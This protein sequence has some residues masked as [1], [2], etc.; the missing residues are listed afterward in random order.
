MASIVILTSDRS[1]AAALHA[2]LVSAGHA[3]LIAT[4]AGALEVAL[5]RRPDLGVVDGGSFTTESDIWHWLFPAVGDRPLA[6][7][8]LVTEAAVSQW[9]THPGIDDM[10][11]EPWRKPELLGRVRRL[12]WKANKLAPEERIVRQD[13]TIDD[14][15][16]EVKVGARKVDLTYREYQL[17]KYLAINPGRVVR[18]ETLLD[19]VWGMDY[20]GGDRT[21]D[22]HVRRL[23]SKLEDA[24]HVFI[25]TVR[26]V[27]YR[28]RED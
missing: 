22:V 10:I 12:L 25:E 24:E 21:I 20:I 27:G 9:E 8:V 28:F 19:K 4:D 17:L 11:V 6:V 2:D 1:K 14:A 26:N 18:R 15:S 7:I 16:Y 3:C 5:G 23:R 13:L